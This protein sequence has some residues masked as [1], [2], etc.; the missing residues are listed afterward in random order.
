MN[1]FSD[2][3]MNLNTW[4]VMILAGVLVWVIRQSLPTKIN[5]NK[6]WRIIVRILPILAGGLIAIIPGLR[7]IADNLAQSI[8]IGLIGGSFGTTAYEIL[9]ESV[10]A[11]IRG[12]LGVKSND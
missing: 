11:K 7:P 8:A 4:L 9:R 2:V 1:L 6:V 10:P 3:F 5:K 12:K